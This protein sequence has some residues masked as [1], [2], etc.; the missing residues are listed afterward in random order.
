KLAL[1][2][3]GFHELEP[4][5]LVVGQGADDLLSRLFRAFLGQGDQLVRTANGYLKVP[6]YAHANGGEVVSV[7]DDDLTPSVDGMIAAVTERTRVVYLANPENP[8]GT[9]LPG[10]EV[11]RLHAALPDDVLLIL[12]CAYAE[13]AW[14]D[15]YDSGQDLVARSSNVVVCRT[16]SKIYGLAGARVGWAHGPED[17]VEAVR[18]IGLTFPMAGPSVAAAMAALEDQAH[19]A[20]VRRENR[21][22]LE[23]FC[24]QLSRL[25][26]ECV[27]SQTNFVLVRMPGPDES[28]A[29]VRALAEK[30]IRVRRM[31]SPAY[32][33][34]FRVSI[35]LLHEMDA[36]A[37]TLERH[38]TE[39]R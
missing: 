35:G 8:A 1:A 26:V 25:D 39:A 15:D 21:A 16:F 13:Y 29:A 31:N 17:L 34:C 33:N 19:V 20:F 14:A 36:T 4:D 10:N 24:A 7:E 23:R 18:R 5:S 27:P 38:L 37:R 6:N 28:E 2:I 11:E 3:A 22:L 12:D 30:G 9:Y 32:A